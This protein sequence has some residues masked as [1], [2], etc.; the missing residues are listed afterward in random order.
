MGKLKFLHRRLLD[1]QHN[2]KSLILQLLHFLLN[3]TLI[4]AIKSIIQGSPGTPQSPTS[5]FIGRNKI[6]EW[7]APVFDFKKLTLFSDSLVKSRKMML[8]HFTK[9]KPIL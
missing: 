8:F 4:E 5:T 2:I 9:S 7:E 6:K 3:N 1:Y